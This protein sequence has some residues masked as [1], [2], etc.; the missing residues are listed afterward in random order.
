MSTQYSTEFDSD[1]EGEFLSHLHLFR[2]IRQT[3]LEIELLN[4]RLKE[5]KST[6]PQTLGAAL[7]TLRI[8]EIQQAA[9]DLYWENPKLAEPIRKAYY[10][11]TRQP[12]TPTPE[13]FELECFHC[14]TPCVLIF[15]TWSQYKQAITSRWRERKLICKLCLDEKKHQTEQWKQKREMEERRAQDHIKRLRAMPYVEY[16]KTEHWNYVRKSAL[17]RAGYRCQLCYGDT[18][19]D[20]HHRT[21]E[22]LGYEEWNDVIAICRLCHMKHH[23][24]IPEPRI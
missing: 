16:L 1:R 17:R 15:D 14:G 23:D 10:T 22:R 8:N 12:L 18:P 3:E 11:I 9:S 24:V 7:K 4:N 13:E 21:Y 6:V 20:V 2:R 19:L 5:L